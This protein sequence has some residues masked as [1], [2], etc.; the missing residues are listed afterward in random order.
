MELPNFKLRLTSVFIVF[1]FIFSAIIYRAGYLQLKGDA[2]LSRLERKQFHSKILVAARRGVMLDRTGEPL[3]I[4]TEV[5]S[6]AANPKKVAK[7]VSTAT[8]LANVLGNSSKAK[9]LAKFKETRDFVWLKRKLTDKELQSLKQSGLLDT[10]LRTLPGLWLVRES[11]RY[12][13]HGELASHVLGSVNIDSVGQEGLERQFDSRLAGTLVNLTAVKD[14]LG[15]PAFYDPSIAGSAK[16]GD[17]VQLTIDASLQYMVEQTLKQAISRTG[18]QSGTVIVMDAENGELLSVANYPTFNPNHTTADLG[19]RRNRAFT[20]GYE[21]GSTMKAILLAGALENGMQLSSKIHGEFGSIRIQGRTISESESHEKFEWLSLMDMIKVSS[22][23]VS[24]KIALKLG[25]NKMLE[26]YQRFGFEQKS[27]TNFPGEIA[28]FLPKRDKPWQPLTVATLGFGQGLLA[29]P[30][31]VARAY[32]VFIN[33]GYLVSPKLIL[34]KSKYDEPKRILSPAVAERVL[35]ALSAVTEEGGTG[36]NARLSGY[37]I[38]GKTG[39]AQ[40]VDP[41]TRKYSKSRYIAS[42][43]GFPVKV[44]R[45]IVVLSQLDDPRGVYYASETAAPLFR[46]VLAAVTR[47]FSIPASDEVSP[48]VVSKNVISQKTLTNEKGNQSQTLNE[49]SLAALSLI[50]NETKSATETPAVVSVVLLEGGAVKRLKLPD[51]TGLSLQEAMEVIRGYPIKIRARG[52]GT[53]YGQSPKALEE[54]APGSMLELELGDR[55]RL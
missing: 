16:D 44:S 51:F 10:Q 37:E 54:V 4:N 31:Q 6:L 24:A 5:M 33:G 30:I 49:K 14:A 50:T 27:G 36:G 2:R 43:V 55:Q 40:T 35:S 48:L 12:Y 17:E 47:R 3:A 26:L 15:R 21:P 34:D 20:D 18:A 29:T 23:V 39:T 8:L 45:K 52:V 22:N 19:A 1:L 41:K 53:I 9:F 42:F 38:A 46:E 11:N 7:R 28:G 13:P 25:R 32:A